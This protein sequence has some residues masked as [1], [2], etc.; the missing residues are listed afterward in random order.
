MTFKKPFLRGE[1][2]HENWKIAVQ[3]VQQIFNHDDILDFSVWASIYLQP[4]SS[5]FLDPNCPLY[6][7]LAPSGSLLSHLEM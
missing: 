7:T 2:R 1:N 3:L 6:K 4:N 5:P